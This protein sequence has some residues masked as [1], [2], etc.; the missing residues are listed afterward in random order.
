MKIRIFLPATMLCLIFSACFVYT[1]HP[2]YFNKDLFVNTL[3][4]GNW[5][6]ADS[7][8]WQFEYARVPHSATE[9]SDDSTGYILKI[10]EN[11]KDW[12][13]KT[14][15]VR[16]IKLGNHYFADFCI[17]HYFDENNM[18]FFDMHLMKVHTFA[19]LDASDSTVTMNWFSQEWFA[20]NLKSKKIRIKREETENGVLITAGTRKLQRFALKYAN[21]PKAYDGGVSVSLTRIKPKTY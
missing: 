3:L 2:L 20:S 7:T 4:L 6:N 21:E 11:G 18:D 10:K 9:F 13:E 1:F 16:I 12:I 14:M 19:R 8:E 5:I 17:N 15:E